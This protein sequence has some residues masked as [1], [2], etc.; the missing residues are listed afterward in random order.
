MAATASTIIRLDM[1]RSKVL[2][3]VSGML[4]I[5]RA[6]GPDTLRCL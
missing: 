1:R 5:S 4:R 2:T 3:E 6:P